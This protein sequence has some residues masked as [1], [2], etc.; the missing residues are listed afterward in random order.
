[1]VI[2]EK[3]LKS[4]M[5]FI[6]CKNPFDSFFKKN[7]TLEIRNKSSRKF[8]EMT[9]SSY[10]IP[11]RLTLYLF[12]PFILFSCSDNEQLFDGGN[13]TEANP[14]QI[15]TI[16]QLQVIGDGENLDKHF[17]QVAD[18][19]AA[20]F[21]ENGEEGTLNPIGSREAPFTGTYNGNGYK[22]TGTLPFFSDMNAQHL[23]LF[24][25]LRDGVIENV[26]LK[27]GTENNM[28]KE[29]NNIQAADSLL[30]MASDI[31]DLDIDNM[32]LMGSLVGFNDGGMIRNVRADIALS[33][34]RHQIGG[35]AGYSSG[36][37]IES[38]AKV[39]VS[40]FGFGGGL[41]VINTG[42]IEE[43]HASGRVSGTGAA[44]GLAGMN[45]GGRNSSLLFRW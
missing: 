8:K 20:D 4:W 27:I 18:I 43:S 36:E 23:G 44:G 25:Y 16:K 7:I 1:M 2:Q 32:K 24:G 26:N 31:P 40:A 21:S 15:S 3:I 34:R 13:G 14:Y 30:M 17:I 33:S 29:F 35:L 39:D 5:T 28:A 10:S 11:A 41:V 45:D 9:Q 12:I 19:D 37:I 38:S 6:N 42:L 22:I